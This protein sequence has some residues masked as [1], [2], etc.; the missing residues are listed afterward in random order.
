MNLLLGFLLGII[1]AT[2]GLS[3]AQTWRDG[4]TPLDLSVGT[5]DWQLFWQ[6]QE[7]RDLETR[8]ETRGEPCLR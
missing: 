8:M 1:V 6:Q 5:R 3:F 2:T 4:N 7:L